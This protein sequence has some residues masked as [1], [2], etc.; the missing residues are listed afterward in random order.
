[1]GRQEVKQGVLI[2]DDESG[3]RRGLAELVASWGYAAETAA[4]GAEA[5]EKVAS[6]RPQ[7]VIADLVMPRMDGME[8]LGALSGS[9][10]YLAFVMLTAKGTIASAVEA[11][12]QG[13]FDYLTKPVDTGQL[14]AVLEKATGRSVIFAELERYQNELETSGR[15]G[16]M[17]GQSAPMRQL[18]QQLVQAG[19]SAASVLIV[20]ESGTGKEL[21]A[22]TLHELSPRHKGP[23]VPINCAAI[24][25][26]LLESEIFGHEKG[27]FTGAEGR[28]EGCFELAD[29]GT[30]FLDEVAEMAP[31]T[32]VKLLR[33]LEERAFRRLGGHEEIQVDVRVLAATNRDPE[34]ALKEGKLREDLYYRLNV[35][36]MELPTLRERL[37][38]L[39]LL[40]DH[41]IR[42]FGEANGKPL[43]GAEPRALR[44]LSQYHWPGN[45][46]ELRN[47]IERAVIVTSSE[48]IGLDELPSF[49][50]Q[51]RTAGAVSSEASDELALPVGITVEQAERHLILKTLETTGQNKTRAAEILGISLKTL[52]NKL[53]KYREEP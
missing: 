10:G 14:K 34:E 21:V 36:S 33:V 16:Q 43:A 40:V 17:V 5:L 22:H 27:A 1:M 47:V 41:F 4:D 18:Y 51:G 37:D 25:E 29:H 12:K 20:G 31:A 46:R 8:L 7:V 28:R 44:A 9:L 19:P 3:S 13:A 30:L 32:Q 45:V 2:V 26:S 24:P 52:H 23:F 35:F 53:K 39:P 11:M 42:E 49:V 48:L 50:T 6:F 38:D 15:F